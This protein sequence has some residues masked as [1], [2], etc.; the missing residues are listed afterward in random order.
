MTSIFFA[1]KKAELGPYSIFFSIKFNM[2]WYV[3]IVISAY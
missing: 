1:S 2:H 3:A